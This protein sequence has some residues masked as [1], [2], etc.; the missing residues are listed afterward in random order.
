MYGH[1]DDTTTIRREVD[2]ASSQLGSR[3]SV[4]SIAW[5]DIPDP[6]LALL[7]TPQWHAKIR[8]YHWLISPT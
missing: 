3:I 2:I 4:K 6:H 1:L 8:Q 5:P 7:V